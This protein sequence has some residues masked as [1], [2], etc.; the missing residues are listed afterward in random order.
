MKSQLNENFIS[1]FSSFVNEMYEG[2]YVD[3]F[4]IDE[5][6]PTCDELIQCVI[7]ISFYHGFVVVIIK[8][9]KANGHPR[10]KTYVL[11]ECGKGG[12]YIKYKSNAQPNM[13]DI[14]KC[15]CSFKLRG[16]LIGNG[17]W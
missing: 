13:S 11:L 8:Y 6:F 4:I 10:E 15:D 16:K 3:N 7:G 14:R 9:D 17:E 5:I 1:N 2:D 12:K